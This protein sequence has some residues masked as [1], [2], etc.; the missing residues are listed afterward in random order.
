MSGFLITILYALIITT[1]AI[2]ITHLLILYLI[3]ITEKFI[4]LLA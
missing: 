4:L 1:R 3:I 2:C